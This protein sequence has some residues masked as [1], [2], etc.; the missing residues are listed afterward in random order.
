[1]KL[2]Q[3]K[4]IATLVIACC[5]LNFSL[6]IPSLQAADGTRV[7]TVALFTTGMGLKFGSTFVE[8]SAQDS[9]DLY[10]NSATQSD[11]A[12]HRVDFTNK[13]DS[14]AIMS[15]IGIGFVGLAALISIFDNMNWISKSSQTSLTS[16]RLTPSYNLH[17]QESLLLLQRQF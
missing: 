11:I 12:K 17:T 1:M 13:R 4:K 2:L 5:I 16:L 7:L 10:L 14:S 3:N 8:K 9:F 6:A 15:R